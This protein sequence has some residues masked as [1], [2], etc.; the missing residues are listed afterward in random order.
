V[1]LLIGVAAA[2]VAA[3]QLTKAIAAAYLP[4][5]DSVALVGDWVRFT[6]TYNTGSAFGLVSSP[7]LLVAAGSAVSLAV[8]AYAIWGRLEAS[9]RRRL[10]LGLVLGGSLGNLVD[11]TRSG[12][13]VDFVDLRVWPVFNLADIAITVGVALLMLDIARRR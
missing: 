3:D 4:S 10:P 1:A 7:T 2:V 13:V 5:S 11:R 6:L 12:A 8:L 9:P